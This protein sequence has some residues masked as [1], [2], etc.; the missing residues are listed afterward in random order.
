M[1][2]QDRE[3]VLLIVESVLD[4]YLAEQLTNDIISEIEQSIMDNWHILKL[5][6]ERKNSP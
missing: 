1:N 2:Q 4:N 6:R 3:D 5:I